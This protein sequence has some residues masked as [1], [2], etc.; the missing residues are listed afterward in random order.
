[1]N[2]QKFDLSTRNLEKE[3]VSYAATA[4][5]NSDIS[6]CCLA[7]AI[8]KVAGRLQLLFLKTGNNIY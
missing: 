5:G 8:P 4:K 6:I 1:M 2:F 3:L 7:D